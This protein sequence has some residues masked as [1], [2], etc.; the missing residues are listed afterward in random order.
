MTEV[1]RNAVT[2]FLFDELD[3]RGAV[4]QLDD[5]WQRI[6]AGRSYPAPVQAM[7]GEMCAIS[8]VI[9]AN[10]KQPG[11]LTFQLS[12]HGPV[13]LLVIDCSE[14]LNLRGYARHEG[15][16]GAASGLSTLLGDGRLLMSLETEGARQPYQSYVPLEGD[17]VAELFEHYLALS[18]QQPARL[19]L[20][21]SDA[22]AV[23]LFLQKLPG[24]DERD[25]D[26]WNRIE[27]L[28]S[29]VKAEELF[30][31]SPEALLGRLFAEETLRVFAP[32]AVRHDFP[33]DRDKIAT[34]LRSLGRAEIEDLLEK[35]GEIEIHDDL[36]NHHYRFDAEE[37]RAL[38]ADDRPTLH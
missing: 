9:G 14:Q 3:I 8:A 17:T 5:V 1:S 16:I 26:G 4:V 12:G 27:Q 30:T 23:G 18:E 33:P 29:T 25:A 36:S 6:I 28:A 13:S 21:A 2:R 15:E 10:L 20:F 34:M 37:A 7:L 19:F 31:L 32:V 38:F 24:A 35:H 22:H 11:R